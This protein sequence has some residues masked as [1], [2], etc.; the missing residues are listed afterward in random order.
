[1]AFLLDL[2]LEILQQIVSVLAEAKPPSV[3]LLH[4][5]PSGSLL[6]SGYHPLKDLSQACRSTHEVCFPSLFSAAKVNLDST[7]GFL[8]HSESHSLSC[9][10]YSLVLY[11][12]PNF[13]T[14]KSYK[15]LNYWLAMVRVIDSVQPSVITIVLPPSLFADIVPYQ[16]HLEDEWA[17]DIPYQVLQLMMPR[18]L[19][20]SSETSRNTMDLRNIFQLRPWTHCTFNQGSSIK[21]YSTYEYFFK[22]APSVFYPCDT[23]EF[24]QGMRKGSLENITSVDYI[25]VF[26]I[27]HLAHFCLCID[28][29]KNL[30]CLRVQLAPTSNNHV[31]DNPA[32]LGK[33]QTGDLWQEFEG[34]YNTL[35]Q[36]L[37]KRLRWIQ[38]FV[39]LDYANSS[40]HEPIDR[41]AGQHLLDWEFDPQGG[42]WTRSEEG[43]MEP[44]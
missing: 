15:N 18:D 23:K 38:E 22:R 44:N 14:K 30:K 1:M 12:D 32:A 26:P 3:K 20:S 24:I 21:G 40:L 13:Q 17:F 36:H 6:R 41:S 11:I 43:P 16:L 31:L 5:E 9:H 2:P 27:E 35:A 8:R 7:G 39:S 34:C 4:E 19:T 10:V 28:A 37:E 42:R 33:C 25:S 29:M